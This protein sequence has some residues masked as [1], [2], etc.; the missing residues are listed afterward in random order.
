MNKP[1]DILIERSNEIRK[2]IRTAVC[3]H[4]IEDRKEL[5]LLREEYGA[6]INLISFHIDTPF[7]VDSKYVMMNQLDYD[8][9]TKER[10]SIIDDMK[11]LKAARFEI[12]YSLKGKKLRLSKLNKHLNL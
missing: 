11:R 3:S 1:I 10:L 7:F 6:A 2:T 8:E 5:V 12:T 4:N 9:L